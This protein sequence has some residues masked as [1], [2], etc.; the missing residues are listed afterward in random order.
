V[1]GEV[2]SFAVDGR[3]HIWVLHRPR[4]IPEAKR[5]QAA[6]PVLEFDTAGKQLASWGGPA[7]GYDWPEREHGIHV[8]A[9]GFVWISGNGGWPRPAAGAS[10]DDMILK[11]TAAGTLVMQIGHRGKGMGNTDTSN[12]HQPADVFVHAPTNELFV[13]D[14][15]G[16]QRVVVFDAERGAFK[17]MWGAYGNPPPSEVTPNPATP[18]KDQRARAR[19]RLCEVA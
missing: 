12:V 17:R 8:D 2:S 10:T 15:Y 14:G 3:D 19:H 13:A 11:F 9:K 18:D 7:D 6:P 5:A 1:L 16:N 4:S